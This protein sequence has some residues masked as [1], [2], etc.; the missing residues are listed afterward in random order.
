[1]ALPELRTESLAL[2]AAGLQGIFKGLRS[3]LSNRISFFLPLSVLNLWAGTRLSHLCSFHTAVFQEF[4][5]KLARRG[6]VLWFFTF[7]PF[8]S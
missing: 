6:N 2:G 7:V 5:L 3:L 1:M 8:F 4:K